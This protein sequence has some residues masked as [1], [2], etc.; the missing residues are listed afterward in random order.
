MEQDA[1]EAVKKYSEL[2][3]GKRRKS[4]PPQRTV[5]TRASKKARIDSLPT[6]VTPKTLNQ[7]MSLDDPSL[8]L[9]SPPITDSSLETSSPLGHGILNQSSNKSTSTLL[10]E[11]NSTFTFTSPLNVLSFIPPPIQED[12]LDLSESKF[13]VTNHVGQ[14]INS[15]WFTHS[16]T[17]TPIHTT[18]RQKTARKTRSAGR[19]ALTSVTEY[20]DEASDHGT[21]S[22]QLQHERRQDRK[23]KADD[24]ELPFQ[25]TQSSPEPMEYIEDAP[26]NKPVR[27]RKSSTKVASTSVKNS[28]L[29]LY[30]ENVQEGKPDPI[31]QPEVWAFKRQQ[32]CE[33]LPYYNAYQSGAYTQYGIARSIMIDKEV[34][35]RDKFQEQVIITSV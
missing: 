21:S 28:K 34:S 6:V 19:S 23:R 11:N 3:G 29:P 14:N 18:C 5:E 24:N 26:Q 30:H 9:I 8:S 7:P 1:Q 13:P 27:K 10:S 22:L 25:E 35:V 12:P 32:L 31:G 16:S 4:V 17:A 2:T 20:Y 15:T 33:T